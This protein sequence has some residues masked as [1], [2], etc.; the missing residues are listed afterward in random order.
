MDGAFSWLSIHAANFLASGAEPARER[1]STG[2]PARGTAAGFARLQAMA[3]TFL[4]A[5]AGVVASPGP[6]G[7]RVPHV[8]GLR[9]ADV[10]TQVRQ[11]FYGEE[12]QRFQRGR[13]EVFLHCVAFGNARCAAS[14]SAAGWGRGGVRPEFR[15]GLNSG[16]QR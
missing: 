7:L 8:T 14:R 13:D 3:A 11:G 2:S 16:I 1:I 6:D 5:V 15:P 12:V 10:G 9:L 4:A